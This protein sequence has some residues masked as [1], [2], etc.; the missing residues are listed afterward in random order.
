MGLLL[1][2]GWL[3]TGNA[4]QAIQ[5]AT[6]DK[7]GSKRGNRKPVK[8]STDRPDQFRERWPELK[9]GRNEVAE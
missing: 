7:G 9:R 6:I 5:K 2:P 1:T 3:Q 8:K 4:E